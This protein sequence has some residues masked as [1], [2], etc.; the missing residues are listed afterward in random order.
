MQHND[1]FQSY[2]QATYVNK[3]YYSYHLDKINVSI[4]IYRQ[5][6]SAKKQDLL[7]TFITVI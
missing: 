3:Y 4:T 7:I 1:D 2:Q 5:K 6:L